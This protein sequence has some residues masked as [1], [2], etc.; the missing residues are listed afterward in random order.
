MRVVALAAGLAGG[1]PALAS[2]QPT[3]PRAAPARAR[4][5][6]QLRQRLW[7]IA[8]DRI[9]LSD[10]QMTKLE[11]SAARFDV[12]RRELVQQE[13]AQRQ[14]LRRELASGDK[15]N[16]DRVSGAMDKLLQLQRQRIDL[17]ADEQ[18]ELAGYMTPVQRAK[19]AALQEQIRRRVAAM[20]RQRAAKGA[21]AT[22]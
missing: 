7:T 20:Q 15:A 14:L 12:R 17:Q 18:K 8:K 3:P 10:E 9:G 19:Y 2:A 1:V 16:E 4:L 22:K 21:A 13:R 5:E 11:A 6:Q